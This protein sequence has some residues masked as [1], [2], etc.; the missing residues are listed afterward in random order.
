[1]PTLET[2][3]SVAFT[4]V[5]SQLFSDHF[6]PRFSRFWRIPCL[7]WCNYRRGG[8]FKIFI[9]LFMPPFESSCLVRFQ[10]IVVR[11]SILAFMGSFVTHNLYSCRLL[12]LDYA[13]LIRTSGSIMPPFSQLSLLR[14]TKC[15]NSD[16]GTVR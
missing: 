4:A 16:T 1:M 10:I 8:I 3:Y 7:A 12:N 13:W 5:S 11:A 6:C 9:G 15:W 2:F 14:T